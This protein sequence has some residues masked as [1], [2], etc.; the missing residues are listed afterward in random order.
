MS[1][2]FNSAISLEHH[3]S[4]VFVNALLVLECIFLVSGKQLKFKTRRPARGGYE[5]VLPPNAVLTADDVTLYSPGMLIVPPTAHNPSTCHYLAW[6]EES[7]DSGDLQIFYCPIAWDVKPTVVP[8]C[9]TNHCA[10][11]LIRNTI[12][13]CVNGHVINGYDMMNALKRYL[14][15]KY[16]RQVKLYVN[17][18]ITAFT[19]R[20]DYEYRNN[21]FIL[22]GVPKIDVSDLHKPKWIETGNPLTFVPVQARVGASCPPV[23]ISA[24]ICI[25][26]NA[27]KTIFF[28]ITP[29]IKDRR[30]GYDRVAKW[31]AM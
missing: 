11:D 25:V 20:K 6:F 15:I 24:D 1:V 31:Y 18:V 16:P 28:L 4:V 5:F 17:P 13:Y 22:D 10:I 21:Q 2:P 19:P 8:T 9:Y 12:M 3:A 30:Y 26:H 27:H 29:K 14:E 23:K 7:S